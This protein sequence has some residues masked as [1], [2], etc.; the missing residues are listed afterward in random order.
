MSTI[1]IYIVFF[2]IF[3]FF[4]VDDF[5]DIHYF[6][7]EVFFVSRNWLHFFLSVPFCFLKFLLTFLFILSL[8]SYFIFILWLGFTQIIVLLIQ[9]QPDNLLIGITVIQYDWRWFFF[10]YF[11]YR[12]HWLNQRKI[13]WLFRNYFLFLQL[14]QSL[15][16]LYF[17]VMLSNR[18]R[19]SYQLKRL[20]LNRLILFLLIWILIFHNVF[21][22]WIFLNF[23]IR[24]HY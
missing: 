22:R 8:I 17:G 5:I 6:I 20:S 1:Q 15:S 14:F 16:W 11:F 3:T 4:I 2:I 10:H 7:K 24:L 12:G 13:L 19:D 23:E 21:Y 18:E 9:Y